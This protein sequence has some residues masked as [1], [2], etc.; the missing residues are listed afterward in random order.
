MQDLRRDIDMAIT[1]NT[2]T[3]YDNEIFEQLADLLVNDDIAC[4]MYL[5]EELRL[6]ELDYSVESLSAIDSYLHA[7]HEMPG[8]E[9]DHF[10]TV[11]RCGAY[12]GEVLRR[13]APIE[14]NWLQ[15]DN[16]AQ[17]I[18]SAT[19]G[20]G[21]QLPTLGVLVRADGGITFPIAKPWKYLANGSEDSTLFFANAMLHTWS[22]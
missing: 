19:N 20:V 2:A 6:S 12:V 4:E 8:T 10:R 21:K 7:V 11:L 13:N 9:E 15:Y 17:M 22:S 18:D 3:D 14:A 16:A 5:P 1:T